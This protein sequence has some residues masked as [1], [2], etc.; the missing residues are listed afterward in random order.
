MSVDPSALITGLT[1]QDG[2]F[3]A[4]LLLAKDYAVTG[5]VRGA[6]DRPLGSSEHLRGQVSIVAGDLERPG[7]LRAAI[8]RVRPAE[9]YHLAGPS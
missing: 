1:G 6:E 2:S 7:T 5:V 9:I 8:E 3:L 4:E